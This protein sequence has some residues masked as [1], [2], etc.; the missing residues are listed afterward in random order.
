MTAAGAYFLSSRRLG[1]RR[2]HEQDL[3]LALGLWG[4]PRVTRLIDAR[5]RLS[6]DE[7][8][9]RLE[10]E[11]AGEREHAVQYWPM[12]LLEDG[13]HVGCCGLRP[14]AGSGLVY[15]LGVHVRSSHWGRGF[16]E[17]ACR[18]V[19]DH[20]FSRLGASGLFAGHNPDNH[21]S[22]RLLQKLGFR[23]THDELYPPT[24]LR[25]PSYLLA[26]PDAPGA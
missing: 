20:A 11:I 6:P 15:E 24:G 26:R 22:R 13:E 7:V 2:W 8:R 10:R 14:R 9:Q 3:E 23:H 12:F 18:A 25:H 19:I 17:E 4:D 21:A 16:A 5:G 1:F